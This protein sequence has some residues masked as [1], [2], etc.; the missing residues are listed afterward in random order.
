MKNRIT[1]PEIKKLKENE[2]FVFGSNANGDHAGGAAKLAKEKFFAKQGIARGRTGS[3]YAIDTMSGMNVLIEQI[4]PFLSAA[5]ANPD[6]TFLVT[7]LGCGIAGYTPEEIAPLFK[8]A[9]S[10]ENIHLPESFWKILNR[11]RGFKAFKK[12]FT[13]RG[14]KY[15]IGKE[16]IHEGDF[17]ICRDGFHFCLDIT[18][19]YKYYDFN[20]ESTI[21]CEVE[22]LGEIQSHEEDSKIATNHLKII[23]QLTWD[24][25]L[26]LSNKGKNN[27]GHSNAGNYNAGYNNAGNDNAGNDNAGSRNAG[28]YNAGNYNAGSRNAGYNN[29]GNDNAGAF[30]TSTKYR[31]FNKD[32]DWTYEDFRNS[33]AFELLHTIETS[34]YVPDYAMSEQEKKDYPYYITTGGFHRQID[35]KEAFVNKW[36]NWDERNRS[37][38]TSLPNFDSEIFYITNGVKL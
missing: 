14:F 21:I 19:C 11:V 25:V 22:A 33:K 5:I 12:D 32:T 29:A 38:F 18:D 20:K 6:L 31:M 9:I 30:N 2:I 34:I 1:N 8:G 24:E 35:F 15:E 26:D 37:A 10:M 28:N 4:E 17:R 36:N 3:C 7:E 16:Y 27:L 13:C 23:R